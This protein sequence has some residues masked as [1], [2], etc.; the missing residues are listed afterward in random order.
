MSSSSRTL[1]VLTSLLFTVTPLIV[2][3]C[4]DTAEPPTSPVIP[5]QPQPSVAIEPSEV[6]LAVGQTAQLHANIGGVRG[7][8]FPGLTWI[9]SNPDVATV[10]V[11]GL[12]TARADGIA[13]ITAQV[14]KMS[15]GARVVVGREQD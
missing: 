1:S 4:D 10:S 8:I 13:I 5:A 12:V 3:G 7:H 9:S 2:V 14:G 15:A 11:V 6:G